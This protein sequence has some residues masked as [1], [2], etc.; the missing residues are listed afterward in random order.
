MKKWIE[1]YNR[2]E[3]WN[4]II[5]NIPVVFI[6]LRFAFKRKRMFF[7]TAL[8]PGVKDGG[9]F[10]ESK[11]FLLDQLPDK[12][13]PVSVL[14]ANP[15][16]QKINQIINEHKINFPLIIKPDVGERGFS[17]HL[18]QDQQALEKIVPQITYPIVIQEYI[19][20]PCEFAIL[21]WRIP[22]TKFGK[23]TSIT[24]K[25]FL[26]VTGDGVHSVEEL[27]HQNIR[28]LPQLNRL[29]QA[30]T[31]ILKSIPEKGIEIIIEEIG[32]HSRGTVFKNANHYISDEVETL[33]D[34]VNDQLN[35]ID[36]CRYDLKCPSFEALLSNEEFK[37]VEINGVFGEPAHVYDPDVLPHQAYKIYHNHWS[38]ISEISGIRMRQG[39]KTASFWYM[40]KKLWRHLNYKKKHQ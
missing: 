19:D 30:K 4:P 35:E 15:S 14:I 37:I 16:T 18:I 21:H 11:N 25:Q 28:A 27:L 2:W 24:E 7:F 34:K 38:I 39:K 31:A 22:D 3:Y 23:I 6:W 9:A 8:N 13:K 33:F 20:W 5:A 12:W 17:V 10:G 40:A 29:K 36:Y 1:K 26:K 32:N